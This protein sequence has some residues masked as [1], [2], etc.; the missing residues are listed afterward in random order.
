MILCESGDDRCY[1]ASIIN[2][3]V[4]G[5]GS[6]AFAGQISVTI[7]LFGGCVVGGALSVVADA[8]SKGQQSRGP[9]SDEEVLVDFVT[10]CIIVGGPPAVFGGALVA[11]GV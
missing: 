9:L 4:L 5:V 3:A 7:G 6:G 11:S 2:G 10:G 8:L 1:A